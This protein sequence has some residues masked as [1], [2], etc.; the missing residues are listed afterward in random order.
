MYGSHQY[1]LHRYGLDR[2]ALLEQY[3][4]YIDFFDVALDAGS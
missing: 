3:A 2:R 4:P 1:D